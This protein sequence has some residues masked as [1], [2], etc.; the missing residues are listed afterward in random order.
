MARPL[1]NRQNPSPTLPLPPRLG[2]TST[3]PT[4]LPSRQTRH[5][6]LL[7]KAPTR[8]SLPLPPPSHESPPT[9]LS[10]LST[11]QNYLIQLC[12]PLIYS[13]ANQFMARKGVLEGQCSTLGSFAATYHQ[14][15]TAA[16]CYSSTTMIA[17]YSS[18]NTPFLY[19]LSPLFLHS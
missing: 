14:T 4:F 13:Q 12:H 5:H 6:L 7:S 9:S 2:E 10:S 11:T 1:P 15:T 19:N 16:T 17:V 18:T 8:T 3:T